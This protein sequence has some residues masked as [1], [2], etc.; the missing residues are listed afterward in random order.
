M[1]TLPLRLIVKLKSGAQ[2]Y[3]AQAVS[4]QR[5]INVILH[6]DRSDRRDH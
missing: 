4:V 6:D 3:F 1:P 5:T 2:F